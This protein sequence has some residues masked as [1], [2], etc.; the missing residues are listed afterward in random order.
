MSESG[1]LDV[2]VR[3]EDNLLIPAIFTAGKVPARPLHLPAREEAL[4][5][6]G[7]FPLL[8]RVLAP[9]PAP[10][11]APQ[12]G[13]LQHTREVLLALKV[14]LNPASEPRSSQQ[15]HISNHQD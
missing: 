14:T 3:R 8:R 7:V 15:I 12:Q 13:G 6:G 1:T 11:P 9:A 10:A 5:P 2:I 4:L